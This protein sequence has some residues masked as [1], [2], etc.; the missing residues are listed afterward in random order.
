VTCQLWDRQQLD[1]PGIHFSNDGKR[2]L[3]APAWAGAEQAIEQP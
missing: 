3:I 2:R 1:E